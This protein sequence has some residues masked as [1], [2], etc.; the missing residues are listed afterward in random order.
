MEAPESMKGSDQRDFLG[1]ARVE[2]GN[3]RFSRMLESIVSRIPDGVAPLRTLTR[4]RL[5]RRGAMRGL[6]GLTTWKEGRARRDGAG[7]G[8]AQAITVYE[9]LFDQL[10]DEAAGAVIAH[11]LAH[12]WL[13]EHV[14]PE[15]SRPREAEADR[16]A[17]SWGFG[18]EL[19]ALDE[20]T[21]TIWEP[22]ESR[23]TLR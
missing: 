21:E 15:D 20:E 5:D 6:V 4:V 11:E 17:S 10:S 22:P 12:A 3:V 19:R 18:R 14:R 16:V 13:N 7:P 1:A 8:G 9:E 23:H 2:S